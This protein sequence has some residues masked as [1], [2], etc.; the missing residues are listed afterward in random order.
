MRRHAIIGRFGPLDV[1]PVPVAA[2][3]VSTPLDLVAPDGRLDYGIGQALD[4]AVDLNVFPT[5]IGLDLL[6]LA[7]HVQAA[8]TRI[9]R[10]TESQDTW[11]REIRLVV[12]V[13]DPVRWTS[14]ASL[15][16]RT[17]DFL[18]GDLWTVG[19]RARPE[20]FGRIVA[21]RQ[22]DLAATPYD[23][24]ALFSGGLDSLIGAIDVLEAGKRAL[25]VSHAADGA[26]SGA[27]ND[28]F[29]GLESHYG[30]ANMGRLRV[31]MSFPEGLVAD[32]Q[33]ENTTRGRSFLFFALG[34]FAGTGLGH[35]FTLRVPENGLIAVNVPLDPLRL[36]SSS[37][38]TTHP[39]YIGRWN[40][41]LDHLGIP[42]RVENPYWNMTKGEMAAACSN[43]QLLRALVPG[44]LSCAAA[45]KGRW[46]GRGIEHCG[47]CLPC[48]IRR[49]A[50]VRAWGAG[51]DLTAYAIP[52]LA[53]QTLDTRRAQGEQVRSF[54]FAIA[55]LRAHPGIEKILIHKPGRL[56]D[57]QDHLDD[58]A[59]VYRRG[60]EEVGSLVAN[61]QTKPL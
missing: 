37:T 11:T 29:A 28:C 48:L 22:Q 5:E 50:L 47:Y 39:F 21:P 43:Q 8:D 13:S 51:N 31:W 24:L 45:T 41:I 49:A 23:A 7:A 57:V 18:T 36:G 58:L 4:D 17:L 1:C 55:R 33:S 56:T 10:T 26:T 16:K 27:Q 34:I 40:E 3:E 25:L 20:P 14:A 61:V 19:F 6:V 54:Q 9:S 46:Q 44:S 53:A 35:R 12:P 60:L 52:D 59:G 32:V 42:A 30:S 38:R 15:L 2:N